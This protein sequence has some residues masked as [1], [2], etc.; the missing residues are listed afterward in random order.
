MPKIERSLQIWLIT[1]ERIASA[2]EEIRQ[3][4]NRKKEYEQKLK[5]QERKDRNHRICKRGGFLES[6]LPDLKG[7]TD[8]QFETF[9]KKTLLT[10]YATR[11]INKVK[12]Q[13]APPEAE[14]AESAAARKSDATAEKPMETAETDAIT[15]NSN[16]DKSRK[17]AA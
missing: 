14:N 1:K 5:A 16:S 6:V 9:I 4:Q 15:S 12:A 11:E 13:N 17:G 7:F 10:D 2:E 3:L 8:A